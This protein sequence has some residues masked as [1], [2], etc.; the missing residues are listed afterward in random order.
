MRDRDRK[1]TSTMIPSASPGRPQSS[2][3]HVGSQGGTEKAKSPQN[4][5]PKS[6]FTAGLLGAGRWQK[7]LLTR[8]LC[9]TDPPFLRPRM[10][11]GG[12]KAPHP[13]RPPAASVCSWRPRPNP[14]TACAAA[15]RIWR[16]LLWS[17]NK[18]IHLDIWKDTENLRSA[19]VNQMP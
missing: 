8:F 18:R 1:K 15:T 11:P 17:E 6:Y 3:L 5:T 12:I 9:R 2:A 7:Q 13:G 16:V 19:N 4:P 14:L 10:G